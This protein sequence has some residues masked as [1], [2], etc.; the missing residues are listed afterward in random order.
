MDVFTRRKTGTPSPKLVIRDTQR[1]LRQGGVCAAASVATWMLMMSGQSVWAMAAGGLGCLTGLATRAS[2][3]GVVISEVDG[4]VEIPGGGVSA[5][6]VT[7][8][9][10]PKFVLQIAFR[11]RIALDAIRNV[12]RITRMEGRGKS[13]GRGH[14]LTLQGTFGAASVRFFDEGKRDQAFAMLREACGVGEPVTRS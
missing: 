7:Q 3:Q 13:R 14:Y 1:I 6:E 9:L 10:S 2:L 8:W 11:H 12:R 5:N 4:S